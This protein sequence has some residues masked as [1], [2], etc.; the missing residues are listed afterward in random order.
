[1]STDVLDRTDVRIRDIGICGKPTYLLWRKPRFR[2]E[3]SECE[4]ATFSERH[5]EILVRERTTGRFAHVARRAKRAALLHSPRI[6]VKARE[7]LGQNDLDR[8]ESVLSSDPTGQLRKAWVLKERSAA[9]FGRRTGAC[10]RG[11]GG[12]YREVEQGIGEFR[13]SRSHGEGLGAQAG[14]PLLIRRHERREARPRGSKGVH[15]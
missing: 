14:C 4:R 10:P 1:V 3:M 7:R 5:S 2:C 15:P 12:W 8:L 6:L 11:L 13:R 9:G